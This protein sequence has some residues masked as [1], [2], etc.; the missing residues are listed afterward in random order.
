MADR[1]RRD[2]AE[3]LRR[4]PRLLL[5]NPALAAGDLAYVVG[6]LAG[7]ARWWLRERG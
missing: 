4:F 1:A 3:R 5:R 2:L 7:G 6:V